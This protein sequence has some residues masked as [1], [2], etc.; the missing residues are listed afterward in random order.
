M[1][2]FIPGLRGK[3]CIL[4]EDPSLSSPESSNDVQLLLE[5]QFTDD[6]WVPE[7]EVKWSS[8]RFGKS[9]TLLMQIARVDFDNTGKQLGQFEEELSILWRYIIEDSG[10]AI[11]GR[12]V[13]WHKK[14]INQLPR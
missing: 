12:R 11:L 3:R 4:N 1:L 14:T 9:L 7:R 2:L 10:R 5:A 6:I 13:L 8:N